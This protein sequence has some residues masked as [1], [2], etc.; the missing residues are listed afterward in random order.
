VTIPLRHSK[1]VIVPPGTATLTLGI[2]QVSSDLSLTPEEEEQVSPTPGSGEP[3]EPVD[4]SLVA[5][6]L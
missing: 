1:L 4:A 3:S 5:H 2:G 6:R